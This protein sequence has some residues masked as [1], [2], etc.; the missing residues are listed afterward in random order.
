MS[1][2]KLAN[3]LMKMIGSEMTVFGRETGKYPKKMTIE[4]SQ[5]TW[6][7]HPDTKP[8]AIARNLKIK[9]CKEGGGK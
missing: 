8:A 7:N 6:I 1:E 4:F 5:M 3:D 9:W 2:A